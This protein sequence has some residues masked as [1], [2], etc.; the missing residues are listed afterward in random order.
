MNML[1][2]EFIENVEKLL[3][4]PHELRIKSGTV[5]FKIDRMCVYLF[6]DDNASISI[7]SCFDYPED[8]GY[9]NLF[10]WV[11]VALKEANKAYPLLQADLY[12]AVE[13]C[14]T[15]I[16][17]PVRYVES[18]DNQMPCMDI[19]LGD[20][21]TRAARIEVDN[22]GRNYVTFG[23]EYAD[24]DY[25]PSVAAWLACEPPEKEIFVLEVEQGRII[26][27]LPLVGQLLK[28]EGTTFYVRNLEVVKSCPNG[29]PKLPFYT[30]LFEKEYKTFVEFFVD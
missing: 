7:A 27:E 24:E 15:L 6:P 12:R 28:Q 8:E 1:R 14:K 25:G 18:H 10:K 4:I 29:I 2:E 30:K 17:M 16:K 26:E 9:E 21:S 20:T 5:V 11:G 19:M 13:L 22:C 23:R 3:G